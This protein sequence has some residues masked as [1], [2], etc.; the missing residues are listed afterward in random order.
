MFSCKII[1]TTAFYRP[2]KGEQFNYH[3]EDQNKGENIM[4]PTIATNQTQF[5]QNKTSSFNQILVRKKK[6]EVPK[7][8]ITKLKQDVN[9]QHI[10]T[11]KGIS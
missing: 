5:H 2:Y 8:D 1:I 9:N 11:S 4:Q 10:H 3:D 7:R 6:T